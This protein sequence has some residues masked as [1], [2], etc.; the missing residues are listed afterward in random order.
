MSKTIR[1]ALTDEIV[2]PL[3]EGLLENKMISRGLNGDDEF[4]IDASKS[5]EYRGA[6]ADCLVALVQAV[7]FSEADKSVG[8]LSDEVKKKLLFRANSIYESIGEEEVLT[9]PKTMVYINC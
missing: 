8:S 5:I 2:Y 3:P 6:F 7:N 1:Q 4:D 9:E